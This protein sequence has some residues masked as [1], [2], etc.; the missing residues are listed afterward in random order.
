[1]TD[2]RQ[3]VGTA[4]IYLLDQFLR[5]RFRPGMSVLD[6]GCGDGRNLIYLLRSGYPVYGVDRSAESVERTRTLASALRP[7]L[8]GENFR[9][10]EIER[11][12]FDDRMFDAVI[13]SAVL[14]FARNESHFHEMLDEIRRVLKPGGFLFARLASDIGI[15][16]LVERLDGRYCRVPDGSARFLVDLEF[17]TEATRRIGGRLLDPIKTV[18]VQNLRCMTTWVVGTDPA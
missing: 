2:L 17:L 13:C 15:E 18:N 6:A 5:G 1:M 14:H 16:D 11:M 4:D 10:E 9:V 12:S 8:P 3:L 7:D